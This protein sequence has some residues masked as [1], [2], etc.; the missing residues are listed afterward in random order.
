MIIMALTI[1]FRAVVTAV[2]SL[3]TIIIASSSDTIAF[4]PAL[5]Y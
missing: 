1:T 4:V 5:H 3:V 2:C